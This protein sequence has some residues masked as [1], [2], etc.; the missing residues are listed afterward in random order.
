GKRPVGSKYDDRKWSIVLPRELTSAV[1]ALPGVQAGRR[2]QSPATLPSFILE[3]RCPV[4]VVR[5]FVGGLFGADG[6]APLL[7]RQGEDERSAVL[8]S[9]AYSQCALPEH[10]DS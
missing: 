9:P 3:D 5:E 10:V 8:T 2:I 4:A 7:H 1:L 6:H